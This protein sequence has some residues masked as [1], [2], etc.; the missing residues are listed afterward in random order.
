MGHGALYLLVPA[1][2]GTQDG[3]PSVQGPLTAGVE[4]AF[5]LSPHPRF[6]LF[7]GSFSFEMFLTGRDVSNRI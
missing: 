2:H 3:E 5:E 1:L 7:C 6:D 4:P